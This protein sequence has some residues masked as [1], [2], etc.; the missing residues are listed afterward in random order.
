MGI[1]HQNDPKWWPMPLEVY[2][3]L[4]VNPN[5]FL[6]QNLILQWLKVPIKGTKV[7]QFKSLSKSCSE[8]GMPINIHCWAMCNMTI[9]TLTLSYLP[10]PQLLRVPNSTK[11]LNRNHYQ[12]TRPNHP[13]TKK[14]KGRP[15]R[16]SLTLKLNIQ[17]ITTN[18]LG[19]ILITLNH[20]KARNSNCKDRTTCWPHYHQRGPRA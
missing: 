15:T 5:W 4:K 8:F 11:T 1:Y 13:L 16:P 20:L 2:F 10:C 18:S 17:K 19:L 7:D 6:Y 12:T 3:W 14:V 9:R